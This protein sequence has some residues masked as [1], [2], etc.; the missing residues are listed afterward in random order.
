MSVFFSGNPVDS[1]S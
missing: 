1:C